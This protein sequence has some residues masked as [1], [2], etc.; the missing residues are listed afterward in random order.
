[1]AFII[2]RNLHLYLPEH[3]IHTGVSENKNMNV[4]ITCTFIGK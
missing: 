2:Y 1:M 4:R 3:F